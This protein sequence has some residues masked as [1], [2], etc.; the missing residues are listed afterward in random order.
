MVVCLMEKVRGSVETG[1]IEKRFCSCVM[2][3]EVLG[4]EA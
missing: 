4:S 1:R 3:E 2:D